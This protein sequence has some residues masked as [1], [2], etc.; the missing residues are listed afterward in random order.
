[1]LRLQEFAKLLTEPRSA[2]T[3]AELA[4]VTKQTVYARLD[5]LRRLGYPLQSRVIR[6]AVSGPKSKVYFLLPNKV[7]AMVSSR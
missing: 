6:E 4:G 1:M 7:P 2:K 5:E 3:L